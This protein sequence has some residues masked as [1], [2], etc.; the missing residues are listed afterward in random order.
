MK[1]SKIKNQKEIEEI[2]TRLKH[3][4]KK[5][6]VLNGSFDLLHSGHVTS[7]EEAKAQGDV[8]VILLNSDASVQKY[9]SI[10]RPII[11]EKERASMLAAM[12][13][14]DFVTLFDETNP[15]AILEKIQ[16]DIYC[17][18]ADWGKN[19]VERSVIEKH[20][21]RVHVLKWHQGI[22]TSKII[23]KILDAYAKPP[24]KAIFVEKTMVRSEKNF[25]PK[26]YTA[27]SI[28]KSA[29]IE[30]LS[31]NLLA[32]AKKYAISLS[33]SWVIGESDAFVLAGREV[34]A[35]T[36]KIGNRLPK[37]LK[38]EP[39]YYAA[40]IREATKYVQNLLA[41]KEAGR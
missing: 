7:L 19:C 6:V 16:P 33:D 40:D 39:H 17:K 18:G 28:P 37:A 22:S 11:G 27:Y 29:D 30:A 31:G 24:Q 4:G 15:K 25:A 38:L 1:Q 8:L 36:I 13:C 5:I 20:G 32:I 41:K 26:G 3:E 9:K 21:G 12:W 34:N 14:V 23:G 2:V 10:K 35:K